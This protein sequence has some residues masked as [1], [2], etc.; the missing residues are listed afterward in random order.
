[1]KGK[2]RNVRG[3]PRNLRGP[4]RALSVDEQMEI[5]RLMRE[6]KVERRHTQTAR[7][8][9]KRYGVSNRTIYRYIVTIPVPVGMEKLAIRLRAWSDERDLRLTNDDLVTLLFVI[10]RHRDFR[11][12]MDAAA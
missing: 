1:V 4:N 11:A 10:A 3:K 9:A 8:L 6:A 2:P 12:Q 7:E 5:Q